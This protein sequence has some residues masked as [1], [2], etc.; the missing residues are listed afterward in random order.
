MLELKPLRAWP[1]HGP[2]I[3]DPEAL[4]RHY[5]DH[6][7]QREMQVLAVLE[8]GPSTVERITDAIY[9]RLTSAL[10]PMARESVLAHLRKLEDEGRARH[11]GS[12]WTAAS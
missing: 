12:Q 3:D 11:D 6:R 4:I 5:L 1:A 9:Q 2:V 8:S 7:H 10:T